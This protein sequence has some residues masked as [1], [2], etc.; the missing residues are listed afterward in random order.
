[1]SAFL[2]S[3]RSDDGI[4]SI[5]RGRFRPIAVIG[6]TKSPARGRVRS[7][8]SARD[9]RVC[10]RSVTYRL[11]PAAPSELRRA[12]SHQSALGHMRSSAGSEFR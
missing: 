8:P 5:L 2:N 7:L 6:Q 9:V 10:T 1:M 3:G 11:V 12:S 4:W